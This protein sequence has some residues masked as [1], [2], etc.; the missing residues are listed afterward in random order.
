MSTKQEGVTTA[1]V[2]RY[3]R[4]RGQVDD[5]VAA[6]PESYLSV[7]SQL[8]LFELQGEIRSLDRQVG[9]CNHA[10]C[11]RTTEMPISWMDN[12][13]TG[14]KRGAQGTSTWHICEV[15]SMATKLS[16]DLFDVRTAIW[17]LLPYHVA[18]NANG[19]LAWHDQ[20]WEEVGPYIPGQTSPDT[21]V[22]DVETEKR[23]LATRDEVQAARV[24]VEKA[25]RE[26]NQ[27]KAKA[28]RKRRKVKGKGMLKRGWEW[29]KCKA[30]KA[31]NMAETAYRLAK[32]AYQK[33]KP[34][35]MPVLTFLTNL[36]KAA[37]RA[38]MFPWLAKLGAWASRLS[39][40]APV[41]LI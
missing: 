15:A 26:R 21:V 19:D 2:A 34:H 5:I 35:V 1:W 16:N 40:F 25:R 24:R 8:T 32:R 17:D 18:D 13:F 12:P 33:V 31:W 22:V 7:E 6:G 20:G 3:A 14:E 11:T 36:G 27:A 38:R 39:I 23:Q 10:E 41:V 28:R 29:L 37:E 9:P 4:L 30:K